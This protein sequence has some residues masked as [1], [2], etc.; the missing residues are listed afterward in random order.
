M[1]QFAVEQESGGDRSYR[2]AGVQW[3]MIIVLGILI[4]L[5]TLDKNIMGLL[6][7]PI[8]ADLNLSDTQMSVVLGLSFGAAYT[9]V[10]IPAGLLADRMSRRN[11]VA[12]GFVLWSVMTALCGLVGSFGTLLLCRSLVGLGEGA[13]MPAAA[14]MIRDGI[15]PS[16]RGRAYSVMVLTPLVG[17]GIAILGGGILVSAVAAHGVVQMPGLGPLHP[18]QVVLLVVGIVGLPLVLLIPT[19]FEPARAEP[20]HSSQATFA[21][22]IEHIGTNLG[23]YL[24]LFLFSVMNGIIVSM[25]GAWTPTLVM[26][27]FAMT[28]A[29]AGKGIGTIILVFAPIGLLLTGAL[30]DRIREKHSLT[31]PAMVATVSSA[32]IAVVTTLAPLTTTPTHFWIVLSVQL[33]LSGVPVGAAQVLLA[34][35]TPSD[36]MGKIQGLYMFFTGIGGL[37]LGPTLA[38]SIGDIFFPGA[39]SLN[40]G[41]SVVCAICGGIAFAMALLFHRAVHGR[42]GQPAALPA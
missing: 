21:G 35:A 25:Y 24:P 6:V 10:S 33:L 15:D 38:A 13:I 22:A 8:K 1:A 4:T 29:E 27:T 23:L 40:F 17:S 26:R 31:G 3:W 39:R 20:I 19:T 5:S 2:S 12:A 11:L 18:W 34:N 16:R 30:I 28:P 36:H 7:Q 32:G 42:Q 14:S 41:M 37:A 9:L